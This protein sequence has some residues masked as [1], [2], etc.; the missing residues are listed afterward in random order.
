MSTPARMPT[1]LA[2][3]LCLLGLG[4]ILNLIRLDVVSA[5]FGVAMIGGLLVGND[6]VRKFMIFLGGIQILWNIILITRDAHTVSTGVVVLWLVIGTALPTLLIWTL[7]RAN[8]REWMFRKNF[9]LDE[10]GSV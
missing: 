3:I 7:S 9:K 8:V 5:A 6:G 1:S 2:I 10:V 4:A